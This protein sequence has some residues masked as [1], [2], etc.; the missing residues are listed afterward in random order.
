M[1]LRATVAVVNAEEVNGSDLA[2]GSGAGSRTTADVIAGVGHESRNNGDGVL[3]LFPPPNHRSVSPAHSLVTPPHALLPHHRHRHGLGILSIGRGAHRRRKN[4]PAHRDGRNLAGA[5][6]H[7]GN[8]AGAIDVTEIVRAKHG[9]NARTRAGG[10]QLGV[11]SFE[12]PILL[13]RFHNSDSAVVR[14]RSQ[15]TIKGEERTGEEVTRVRKN[16]KKFC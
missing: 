13:Q 3:H 16:V 10:R 1:Y 11:D 14:E 5:A 8:V 12:L 7:R 2:G 6:A 9:G 15:E 4:R